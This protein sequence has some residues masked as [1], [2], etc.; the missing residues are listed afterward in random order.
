[1]R[2]IKGF[3]FCVLCMLLITCQKSDITPL[4]T[5]TLKISIKNTVKGNPV[6]LYSTAYTNSFSE[7]YIITKFKYYIS[8]INLSG[9]GVAASHTGYYLIDESNSGSLHFSFEVPVNTY[10]TLSYL[11]GVDSA[12]NVSGAQTGALDPVNDMFWTWNSGYIMAK[13]EGNSPQSPVVNNKVEYHIG[14][15]SGS[16]S[17]LQNINFLLTLPASGQLDIRQGKTSELFIEA[18]IDKWWQGSYNLKIADNPVVTTPG[19]LAK[20]ISTNYRSMFRIV[21]IKNY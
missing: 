8:N 6:L 15:F 1:M 10:S 11:L 5:G 14:G 18:D 21:D 19:V 7:Q 4:L 3:V 17:V 20:N 9:A 16:N 13:L 12:R 2:I